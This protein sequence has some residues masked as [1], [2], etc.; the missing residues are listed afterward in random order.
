MPAAMTSPALAPVSLGLPESEDAAQ[1]CATVEALALPE[2]AAVLQL[3][4]AAGAALEMLAYRHPLG[5]IAAIEASEAR[6]QAAR[7]RLLPRRG[8]AALDLRCAAPDALPFD[9]DRFDVVL[10]VNAWDDWADP[11]SVVAEACGV[12]KPGGELVLSV[13]DDR[14]AAAGTAW[15]ILGEARAMMRHVGLEVAVREIGHG[16]G[17]ATYLV[18]GRKPCQNPRTAFSLGSTAKANLGAQPG[19]S[20]CVRCISLRP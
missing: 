15:E 13:R 17:L 8:P 11:L 1:L 2:D 19:R 12:L 5:L 7:R 9:D 3:G 14:A 10:A 4:L 18:R 16:P 20:L 6:L